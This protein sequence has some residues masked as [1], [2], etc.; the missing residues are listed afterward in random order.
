MSKPAPFEDSF[1]T[2]EATV[3]VRVARPHGASAEAVILQVD[4]AGS[5]SLDDGATDVVIEMLEAAR[6]NLGVRQRSR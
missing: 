2:H 4:C 5:I 6:A 1:T 3:S